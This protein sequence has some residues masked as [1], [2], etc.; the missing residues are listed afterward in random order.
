MAKSSLFCIALLITFRAT[1]QI[2]M[3]DNVCIGQ[4]RHYSVVPNPVP[5]STYTWWINGVVQSG[6]TTNEFVHTWNHSGTYI[7][8][9]QELS[10]DRCPGPVRSGVV[11]VNPPGALCSDCLII[12]EAISVN[13]DGINDVWRIGNMDLYPDA[14]VIIYNRWG[15]ELW[16]SERGYPTPWDGTSRG[17]RLPVDGYHYVIDLHNGSKLVAGSITIVK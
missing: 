9:V 1:G 16:R 12:P 11:Y 17:R 10:A 3:P 2:A 7:L 4:T 5:G 15:Q 13:D 6:V 14:E 8:E